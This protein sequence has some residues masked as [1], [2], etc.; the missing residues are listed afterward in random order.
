MLAGA[1]QN[2]RSAR[3]QTDSLAGYRA[4][5]LT[6]GPLA[7]YRF[8]ETSG[9]TVAD[10]SGH[11]YTGTL[12]GNT[13]F[14]SAG[15]LNGDSDTAM[16]FNNPNAWM[17]ASV[18]VLGSH[19]SFEAWIKIASY[20]EGH[21]IGIY[22]QQLMMYHGQF[23]FGEGGGHYLKSPLGT[24]DDNA[25]HYVVATFDGNTKRIYVD[26]A[27]VTSGP[28]SHGA[29]TGT[30]LTIGHFYGGGFQFVGSIDEPAVYNVVLTPAQI[31]NHYN[32]GRNAAATP[33]P[34]PAP[35]SASGSMYQ[36]TVLNDSP[37]A[38]YRLGQTSGMTV[39]D[40]SSHAVN[41]TLSGTAT[42]DIAGALVGD[43]NGAMGFNGTNT[44]ITVSNPLG[45]SSA[46][47][48]ALGFASRS[49]ASLSSSFSLEAWVKT[50]WLPEAHIINVG[51]QQLLIVG[52][53]FGFGT[54]GHY[55]RSVLLTYGDN[56]YHHVV[57][58]FDGTTKRL[59]VDGFE[60]A[61]VV[62]GQSSPAGGSLVIG[63]YAG[64]G[65]ELAGSIDEVSVY[66]SALS[67]SQV[68]NHYNV[69]R[70]RLATPAPTSTPNPSPSVTAPPTQSP[71]AT[72][73]ATPNPT[74]TP[75]PT[76]AP[77][78]T[79]VPTPAPT[80]APTATPV[81]TPAPTPAPTATPVR[82][83]VPTPIPTATPATSGMINVIIEENHS[84]TE[85][86]GNSSAP[87]INSLLGK[88]EW[89]TNAH[90]VAHPSLPN[91]LALFSGSTQGVTD[92]GCGY[93]FSGPNLASQLKS[94]GQT[95]G[96]YA[97]SAPS[98]IRTCSSGDYWQKHVPWAY[99]SPVTALTTAAGTVN[100]IVP[101]QQDD[102]HDGT[103][104]QGDAWLKAHW[105]T[106]GTTIV[107]WDEAEHVDYT[108]NNVVL[109][110]VGPGVPVRQNSTNVNHYSIL[111]WIESTKGLPCLGNA[112]S[113]S[114]IVL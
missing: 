10:S 37:S 1:P 4:A 11:S 24:Y 88:G 59:Y 25:Y 85:I 56:Q 20:P 103:V 91:Y 45:A 93:S 69:G 113:A 82:T 55:L 94:S 72:P 107:V 13:S 65:N 106:S 38:Y 31:S 19:Y 89:F 99:F 39:T 110:I 12:S 87:F 14:G 48:K 71:T 32:A 15:A 60:S 21:I 43:S 76:P 29:V 97:E 33:V 50:G 100:F 96:G 80:P 27:Q 17:T 81:P 23:Y 77:T 108:P 78:S 52:G 51:S 30:G 98:N 9:S 6:D 53:Q 40:S 54:G 66:G 64:G 46:Q 68:L 111:Q 18:P 42:Y 26:G 84:P 83:P 57:A 114:R 49:L 75:A 7:Y 102:M 63:R 41:A 67:A 86:I 112:C 92:D 73:V 109:I 61:S 44:A 79:P 95:F 34:T 5:V 74:N 62:D 3:S 101:N 58:T 35:T 47:S 36:S 90:G 22:P 104:A 16:S 8:D 105:P 70:Q 2:L 28:E